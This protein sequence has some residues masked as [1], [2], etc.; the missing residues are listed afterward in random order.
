MGSRDIF[1]IH[2]HVLFQEKKLRSVS[3][4]KRDNT[5]K[6][7]PIYWSSSCYLTQV[8]QFCNGFRKVIPL[9]F[10]VVFDKFLEENQ[11]HYKIKNKNKKSRSFGENATHAT[12]YTRWELRFEQE[13]ILKKERESSFLLRGAYRGM[14]LLWSLSV[15]AVSSGC[16]GRGRAGRPGTPRPN[17]WERPVVP[18]AA[19]DWNWQS[20]TRARPSRAASCYSSPCENKRKTSRHVSLTVNNRRQ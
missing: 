15:L 5:K 17:C 9:F 10:V 20:S 16:A 11:K 13:I 2:L 19:A 12:R 14:E 8:R 6:R 4:D 1:F 7:R 18:S 3:K